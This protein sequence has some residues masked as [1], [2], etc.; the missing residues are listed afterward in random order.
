MRKI[1]PIVLLAA[2]TASPA[3]ARE[4]ATLTRLDDRTV[5]LARTETGPVTVWISTGPVLDKGDQRFAT[6]STV[7]TLT[8]PIP[9]SERH[10]VILQGKGGKT[11]VVAERVLPLQQG[12]NFRDIGGYVTKDGRTVKWDKA[13]RSGAM[14]L[15]TDADYALL[16]QVHLGA[17]VDLRSLEERE[18]APDMLDD[19]TGALFLANDYSIKPLFKDMAKSGG[20]NMYKGM[21]LM[22]VPQFRA[23]FNRLL[24]N[25]GAVVYHCSAGQDRTGI[26]TALIYDVL[27]VDRET[28]L[29]DYHRST[30]LRRPQWEMPKVDP[31]DYPNN[32]ILKYYAAGTDGQPAK[33]E[34]LYTKSGASHLAQFF[35]YL[36]QQYGGS[37]GYLKQKV[38]LTD[39]DIAKLRQTMLD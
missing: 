16:D 19:R 5:E 30:E 2:L 28:I 36:D 20:E 12:S 17:I 22:L 6:A 13:F 10:Y 23:L 21:E 11:T 18:V 27:G 29:K 8:L 7:A 33:A 1:A 4:L 38:G 35:T 26:A 32:P 3:L 9:A 15:L 14:P 24:A 37:E 31:A 39:A 25:E 34:P